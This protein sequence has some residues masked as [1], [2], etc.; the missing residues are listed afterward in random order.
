[1][2]LQ[3]YIS[4]VQE[5]LHDNS[6]SIWPLARVISRINQAR[7][8]VARDM[9]CVRQNVT[10]IQLLPGQE[11]YNLL[12]AVAGA[13]VVNGGSNYGAGTTI[14]ITFQSAPA[15]GVTATAIG[16]LSGGVLTS[17]TMT[18]WGSGYTFI[19]TVS[20]GGIGSGAVVTP[21]C[22]FQANPLLTTAVGNVLTPNKISFIWNGERRTLKY[23][24]FL[25][26]D[27][28]ARM[29]VQNFNAPPGIWTVHPQLQQQVYI[30][31]PA[32]QLYLSEWDI[33]FLP[34]PLVAT[35]DFDTSIIDP[36]NLSV[37]WRASEL[38][39]NKLRN[40]GQVTSMAKTYT[41]TVPKIITGAQGI[42]IPNIYNRNFQ[43]RIMR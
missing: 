37:Q 24:N 12:G 3:D 5:I 31:P 20:V 2:Q 33:V 39:L 32:D 9:H 4:D 30:Q 41:E 13:T 34:V 10:G 26:F 6:S 1:M 25:M 15:G 40:S 22:L 36:W 27:A 23:A 18:R 7:N 14:P 16:T 42:R 29:W 19:P 11:I 21:V 8:D 17:V 35:S 28:Y 43:R 38:L